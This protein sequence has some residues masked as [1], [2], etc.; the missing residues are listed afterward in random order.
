[1][2]I[3]EHFVKDY[4]KTPDV[5]ARIDGK[6]PRL[7][8]RHV[9]DRAKHNS[10]TRIYKWSGRRLGMRVG[11][12][13]QLGNAEVEHLHIVFTVQGVILLEHHNI[14]RLDISMYYAFDMGGC[15]GTGYL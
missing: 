8:R 12:F 7:F 6:S 9:T 2:M 13:C 11:R 1:M 4:A 10:L 3:C 14:L 5:C 15:Q